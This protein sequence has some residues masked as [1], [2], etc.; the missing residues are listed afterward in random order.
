MIILAHRGLWRMAEEKNTLTAFERAFAGGF[1]V[2]LD[3]RDLDGALVISHDP[4]RAGCLLFSTVLGLY[5]KYGTPGRMAINIKADGLAPEIAHLLT[6][7]EMH[8]K[9]FVFDMS[10]PDM[11]SYNRLDIVTFTRHSEYE[12]I[13]SRLDVCHG[14]WIDAFEHPWADED[15][16]ISFLNENK[17]VALVS[18]ELHGKPHREAWSVWRNALCCGGKR[19]F[20]CSAVMICTDYPEDAKQFFLVGDGDDQGDII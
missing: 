11:L 9:C 10:V 8:A 13:P 12:N 15:K 7:R 1:G 20:E 17:T 2:E 19:K 4:P 5:Q 18:P 3:V 14:V 16:I 6:E